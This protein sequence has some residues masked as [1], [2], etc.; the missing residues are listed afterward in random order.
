MLFF[1]SSTESCDESEAV[2]STCSSSNNNSS[3]PGGYSVSARPSPMS[4]GPH[5]RGSIT[6]ATSGLPA[7]PDSSHFLLPTQQ[8]TPG[9]PTSSA[10]TPTAPPGSLPGPPT[11]GS[12][13]NSPA[14]KA[15]GDKSTYKTP[16]S[17][18]CAKESIIEAMTSGIMKT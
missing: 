4:S 10:T 18:I 17:C 15:L 5:G 11:A 8:V 2:S 7:T 12:A 16:V 6:R 1:L 9:T 3:I 14:A 13:L